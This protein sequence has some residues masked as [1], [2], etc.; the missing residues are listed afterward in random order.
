MRRRASGRR[1]WQI[2]SWIRAGGACT[3][4]VH[5]QCFSNREV[6]GAAEL[7]CRTVL[8]AGA[9]CITPVKLLVAQPSQR[10]QMVVSDEAIMRRA[11]KRP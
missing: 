4:P 10:R 11:K 3:E 1:E 6:L 8:P 5:L 2:L 9:G 7:P